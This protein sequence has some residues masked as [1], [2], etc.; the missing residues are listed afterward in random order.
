MGGCG[1]GTVS[2]ISL[3]PGLYGIMACASITIAVD[4]PLL[5]DRVAPK[6]VPELILHGGNTTTGC[7]Y[8]QSKCKG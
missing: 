6:M 1:T 2:R 4:H 8:R 5:G 3:Y 7:G